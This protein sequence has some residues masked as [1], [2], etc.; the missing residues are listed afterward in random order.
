MALPKKELL[1]LHNPRCSKSRQAKQILDDE[2]AEYVERRYLDDPLTLTE[3][4]D[5]AKRLGTP[6]I[7]WTRRGESEF[8]EAGLS[9]DSKSAEILTA[10]AEHPILLERPIVVRGARAVVGRPPENVRELL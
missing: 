4:R 8:E 5:L 6:P 7:E 9:K 10:I 3:L 1:L 2:G